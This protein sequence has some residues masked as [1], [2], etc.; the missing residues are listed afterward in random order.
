[1]QT[2]RPFFTTLALMTVL[3]AL[4]FYDHFAV[5]L[6]LLFGLGLGVWLRH[7]SAALWALGSFVV[8][9]AVAALT[10]WTKDARIWELLFGAALAFLGGLIGGGIF[11][12]LRHERADEG[13]RRAVSAD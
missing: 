8:A 12:L 1:M 6:T 4:V 5:A 9:F 11:D 10:G 13:A 3:Q 7:W 2:D